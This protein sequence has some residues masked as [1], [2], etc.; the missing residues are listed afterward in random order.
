MH[1]QLTSRSSRRTIRF[2]LPA[3]IAAAALLA[4]CASIP[5]PT[6]QVALGATAIARAAAAGGNELAPAD[7]RTARDKLQ[8]ANVAMTVKDYPQ[9]LALAQQVQVDARL[10][11]ARAEAGKATK[12]AEAVREGNRV[13]REEIERKTQ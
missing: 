5:P 13:L 1:P 12:A 11:E 3:A 2:G 9:A 6:D 10:A 8:R 7:M 4:A